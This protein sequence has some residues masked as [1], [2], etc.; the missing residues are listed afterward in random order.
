MAMYKMNI[1]LVLTKNKN[2]KSTKLQK[3][4]LYILNNYL[5]INLIRKLRKISIKFLLFDIINTK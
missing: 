5:Y 2:N 3:R 1:H 4:K